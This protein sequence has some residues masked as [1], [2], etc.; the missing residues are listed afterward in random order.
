MRVGLLE[1]LVDDDCASEIAVANGVE[2]VKEASMNNVFVHNGNDEF[3]T[4]AI[5]E[6]IGQLDCEFPSGIFSNTFEN[7]A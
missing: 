7:V 6:I 3:F 1:Q 4:K 5:R 2:S